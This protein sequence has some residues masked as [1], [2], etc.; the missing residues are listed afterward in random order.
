MNEIQ[1]C[2]GRNWNTVK[3]FTI[4]DTLL[5]NFDSIKFRLGLP[6][7]VKILES[8]GI[9]FLSPGLEKS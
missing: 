3:I 7:L 8:Q 9:V 6:R 5:S 4:G 2:W 1:R